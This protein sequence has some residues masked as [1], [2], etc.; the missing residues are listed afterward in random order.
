M[1]GIWKLLFAASV[2]DPVDY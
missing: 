1:V 2:T